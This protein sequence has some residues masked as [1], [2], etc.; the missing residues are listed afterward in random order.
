[1]GEMGGILEHA[2]GQDITKLSLISQGEN[3]LGD[4]DI[5]RRIILRTEQNL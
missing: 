4:L 3:L 1:M 2:G 5:D